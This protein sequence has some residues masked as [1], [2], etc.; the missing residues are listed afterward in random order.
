[1]GVIVLARLKEILDNYQR[2]CVANTAGDLLEAVL[3]EN[4]KK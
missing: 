2:L 4:R 1:M 3:S